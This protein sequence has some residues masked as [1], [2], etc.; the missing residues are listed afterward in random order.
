MGRLLAVAA[1]FGLLAGCGQDGNGSGAPAADWRPWVLPKADAVS[2]PPPPEKDSPAARTELARM[3]AL[4]SSGATPQKRA[5]RRDAGLLAVE[6]WLQGA[7]ERVSLGSTKDPPS[8]SRAYALVSVAMFDAEVAAAHYQGVYRRDPPPGAGA[9]ED[10]PR[11]SSYPSDRAAIA[12]AAAR[13]LGYLFPEYP[14]GRWDLI[15]RRQA[16]LR[17]V[18]GAS[19][20]TDERAGL[21]LG[22]RIGEMVIARARRDGRDTLHWD[23]RRP[24]GVG[25]WRP[26]P[27]SLARPVQPVA[28]NWRPWVLKNGSELR[29]PAPPA[30]G[31]PRFAAEARE[32]LR[33][34]NRL[35]EEQKRI[36]LFWASGQGTSLPAGFWNEIAL[37][38]A[39]E[40][41]FDPARTTRLFALLNVALA[42]AGSAA[43]DAK[44]AYWSPR[45]INAIRDL[46]LDQDFKPFLPTP[47]FPAYVSGHS[48]YSAAAA[49][50][51]ARVFPEVASF[52]RA[53]ARE[54]GLSRIYGG[55]HYA[56]DNEAGLRLGRAVAQKVLTRAADQGLGG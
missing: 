20:P 54:A 29:P 55:I 34:G 5:A 50:V 44:Y 16:R 18:S 41:R 22:R 31:T 32:V 8:S 9:G 1:S 42:D 38:Y 53:K 4:A 48:T 27:G 40:A 13:V 30:Y 47:D 56:A 14:A 52:V 15:A 43:W 6:P 2:V 12:G 35:T 19:F 17:V 26:P 25:T 3:K 45:P 11:G 7:L 39:R 49:E 33:I 28:G 46:G 21:T 24:R 10:L 51:L 37:G 23:G 36:A